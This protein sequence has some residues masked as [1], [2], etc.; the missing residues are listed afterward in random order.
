MVV[1]LGWM[2]D[3]RREPVPRLFKAPELASDRVAPR[4]RRSVKAP[5]V[6]QLRFDV[7]DIAGPPAAE[8]AVA[9]SATA[10]P[11]VDSLRPIDIVDAAA[12]HLETPPSAASEPEAA[13]EP[14]EAVV[15]VILVDLE[16]SPES[17]EPVAPW[18][19]VF[20][21]Q[22]DLKGLLNARGRLLSRAFTGFGEIANN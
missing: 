3:D 21:Q 10:E 6:E 15:E 5:A 12:P 13:P 2:L 11:M 22:D 17:L 20:D 8:P 16:E 4:K 9:E 18:Q 14:D 7:I 1:P 19:P